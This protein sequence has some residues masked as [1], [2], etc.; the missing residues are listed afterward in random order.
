M[1][2]RRNLLI[3]IAGLVV[4]LLVGISAYLLSPAQK[5][6]TSAT[7]GPN[8]AAQASTL[9][10]PSHTELSSQ[11]GATMIPP[12]PQVNSEAPP[13]Y[14]YKEKG[15]LAEIIY[16]NGSFYPYRYD[17]HGDKISK[18]SRSGQTW[19]YLYDKS[20]KP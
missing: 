2:R 13:A 20:H 3:F 5:T 12:Q 6:V 11:S 8:E 14:K 16:P 1:S 19:T 15:K 17:A 9:S 18:T 7:N 10:V 4:C